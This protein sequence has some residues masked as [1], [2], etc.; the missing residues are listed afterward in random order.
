MVRRIFFTPTEVAVGGKIRFE[1][2]VT[3]QAK[4]GQGDDACTTNLLPFNAVFFSVS[5]KSLAKN[6]EHNPKNMK[7]ASAT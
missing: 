7:F 1:L 6:N 4:V 3:L 2:V 5:L